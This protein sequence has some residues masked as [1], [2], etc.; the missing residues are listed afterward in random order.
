MIAAS[1][2]ILL[3][4]SPWLLLGML[5]AGLLHGLLPAGLVARHL[6]GRFGTLKAVVLGIPL[7]LCSCGVI[8]A[9]LGLRQDGASRGATN[10]F[11][12]STPQTGVDSFLVSAAFLGWPFAAWKVVAALVTGVVGGW[13]TDRVSPDDAADH[14]VRPDLGPRPGPRAIVPHALMTLESIWPWVLVAV[15]VSAALEL[16]V[17]Q[18]FYQE[19]AAQGAAVAML[20]TLVVALPFYVC[21]TASVPIAAALVHQGLPIGAALVFL[22]AGPA[23]NLATI[24]AIHK[25]LGRRAVAVY[26]ATMVGGSLAFGFAL[27]GL[28]LGRHAGG[29]HHEHGGA[30]LWRMIAAVVVLGLCA[31][32]ALRDI[33]ARLRSR[34]ATASSPQSI[35]LPVEGMTC[36]GCVKR[37]ERSLH[38]EAGVDAVTVSLEGKLARVSGAIDEARLAAAIERAGFQVP[39]RSSGSDAR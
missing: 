10:G 2:R 30:A 19:V 1:W 14:R 16:W 18:S 31:Y 8:P 15:A 22:M 39:G 35:E 13:L 25:G 3:E 34:T 9:G 7:P 4:L 17:P 38:S 5:A 6:R 32:F 20:G 24:G 11:L 21:A 29:P 36:G 27:N 23:T 28:D 26:L 37:L 33:E 12:I